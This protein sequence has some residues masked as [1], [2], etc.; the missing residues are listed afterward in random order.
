M[1]RVS[2]RVATNVA[3]QQQME[4]FRPVRIPYAIALWYPLV[5]GRVQAKHTMPCGGIDLRVYTA[6]NTL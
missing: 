6:T 1:V 2:R 5:H 3:G 4:E